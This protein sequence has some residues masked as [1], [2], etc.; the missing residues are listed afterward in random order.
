MKL[1]RFKVKCRP[2]RA[3]GIKAKHILKRS[4]SNRM[5]KDG[6]GQYSVSRSV[7]DDGNKKNNELSLFYVRI[8]Y[9]A[10]TRNTPCTHIHKFVHISREFENHLYVFMTKSHK[11]NDDK[12][13]V[14]L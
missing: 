3:Y 11:F 4:V 5:G 14:H 13:I 2:L 9:Q 6:S 12:I 1:A 7:N 8:D 10:N